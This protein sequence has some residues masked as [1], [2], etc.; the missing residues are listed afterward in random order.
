MV[1]ADVIAGKTG[2]VTRCL[3]RIH[4]VT[5][6]NPE[7]IT[8]FD[9]E[10]IVVLNL[11]RAIQACIDMMMH[12]LAEENLGTPGSAGD[13]FTTL[14]AAGMIDAQLSIE[15]KK[16]VGFRNLAI[17]EYDEIDRDLLKAILSKHLVDL[18]SFCSAL[19]LKFG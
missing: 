1:S 2:I 19:I 10:D 18:R 12:V 14:A 15:L 8:S 13:G 11:Q 4:T 16:M 3:D 7:A 17:H 5:G 9:T 6:G